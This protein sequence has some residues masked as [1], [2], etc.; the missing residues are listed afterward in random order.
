MHSRRHF[1][2]AH[3]SERSAICGTSVYGRFLRRGRVWG[4]PSRDMTFLGA[5]GIVGSQRSRVQ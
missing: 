4:W 3:P 5:A 1:M 2:K